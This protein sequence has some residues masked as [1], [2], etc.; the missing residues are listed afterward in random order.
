MRNRIVYWNLSASFFFFFIACSAI[1]SFLGI[2]LVQTMHLTAGQSSIIFSINAI[3]T[4]CL[5]P[6]Y[7]YI[8]DRIGL[9]KGL[10]YFITLMILV[11]GPF[12]VYIYAPLLS[13]NFWVG[14][15]VGSFYFS[16]AF[17]TGMSALE[18][19]IDKVGRKYKFEFGRAR[20]WGSIGAACGS[21]FG[22][23]VININPNYIFW[24]GSAMAVLMFISIL[25]TKIS[26]S[27]VEEKKVESVKVRDAVN[28]LKLKSF[29][30]FM[31]FM[32]GS[33]CVY[34][35]FNQ[36]F[37]VYYVSL[38][39]T[40]AIGNQ[41]FGYLNSVQVFLEAG[42]MFFAPMIVNKIGPKNGLLMAGVVMTIR[43]FITGAVHDPYSVSIIEMAAAIEFPLLI[44]SIFKYLDFNFDNRLASVLYLVGYQFSTQ[45]GTIILSPIVGHMY[46][47]IGF[48]GAYILM[49]I[50]TCVFTVFASITL[51]NHKKTLAKQPKLIVEPLKQIN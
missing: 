3:F 23:M 5:Q 6:I 27:S 32:L 31:I 43:M 46:D 45:I 18:S 13:I 47:S 8:S 26:I 37:S 10:L 15:I 29:W 21:F 9:R 4:M 28:L 39:S 34:Q 33:S 48:R 42:M 11:A 38:F 30:F 20:M 12:C 19:Y 41:V 50:I 44:V 14:A 40:K 25:I 36:L 17:L 22:G 2:W 35:V 51:L 1:F 24:M 49:G 16:L 7:G